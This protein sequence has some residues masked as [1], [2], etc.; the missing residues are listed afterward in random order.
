MSGTIY[1]GHSR[2]MQTLGSLSGILRAELR[3]RPNNMC[4]YLGV[5]R[6]IDGSAV[7]RIFFSNFRRLVRIQRR[8]I[9][10]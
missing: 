3:R 4:R 9:V 2:D 5:V 8:N 6:T 1:D 10:R 7:Q